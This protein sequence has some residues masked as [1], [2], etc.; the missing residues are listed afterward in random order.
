MC[1]DKEKTFATKHESSLSLSAWEE[2]I[3]CAKKVKN[4]T[5]SF[6]PKMV[7]ERAQE[8]E[9]KRCQY[10]LDNV[11]LTKTQKIHYIFN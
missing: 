9:L 8:T 2:V 10:I 4:N 1:C 5:H 7:Y 6:D 3:P 11:K